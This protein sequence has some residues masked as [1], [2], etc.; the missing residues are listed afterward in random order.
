MY[1]TKDKKQRFYGRDKDYFISYDILVTKNTYTIANA[2]S[3]AVLDMYGETLNSGFCNRIG[4]EEV[5]TSDIRARYIVVSGLIGRLDEIMV[6]DVPKS[7]AGNNPSYIPYD[8]G[9]GGSSGGDTEESKIT[10]F[11]AENFIYDENSNSYSITEFSPKVKSYD[12]L[13]PEFTVYV[14][15]IDKIM[16]NSSIDL[17]GNKFKIYH[18]NEEPLENTINSVASV[19]PFL[20]S[21]NSGKARM[22]YSYV[23]TSQTG[24]GLEDLFL[25]VEDEPFSGK[26]EGE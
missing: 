12:R 21:K 18:V 3:Y 6:L 20:C 14:N 1:A 23:S 11:F 4:T 16:A 10:S 15:D 25:D 7:A 17:F 26:G 19:M 22:L 13:G 9:S 2:Y 8:G 5:D 24:L